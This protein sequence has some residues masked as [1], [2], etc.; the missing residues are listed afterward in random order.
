MEDATRRREAL[1]KQRRDVDKLQSVQA[2]IAD[3]ESRAAAHRLRRQV[4][5]FVECWRSLRLKRWRQ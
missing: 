4:R 5:Q 3:E 2:E 1:R